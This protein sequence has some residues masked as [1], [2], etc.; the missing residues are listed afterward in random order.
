MFE[1]SEDEVAVLMVIMDQLLI[2]RVD[3]IISI[4]HLSKVCCT[5]C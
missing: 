4:L 2:V 3:D 5:A 1:F